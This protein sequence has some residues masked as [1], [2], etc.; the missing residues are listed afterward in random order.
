MI[1]VFRAHEAHAVTLV[2]LVTFGQSA[3]RTAAAIAAGRLGGALP[4]PPDCPISG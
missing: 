1:D 3:Y 2:R 4:G